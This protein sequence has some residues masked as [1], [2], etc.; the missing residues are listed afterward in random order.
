[1]IL[2]LDY[3]LE[4]GHAA[5]G[6][7][8]NVPLAALNQLHPDPF[9]WLVPGMLKEKIVALIK[10]LPKHL[11]V[12]FVP[13]PQTADTVLDRLLPRRGNLLDLLA[14]EL[15]NLAGIPV[16]R[17]DFDL[18]SIDPY[19]LMNFRILDDR[20][21]KVLGMGR[22]LGDLQTRLG[23]EAAG[24]FGSVNESQFTRN[25]ITVWDFGDL[26]EQVSVRR[27]GVT[28]LGYPA[29]A[30]RGHH[31]ALR[32]H[33]S[34]G[35][36]ASL[37]RGGLRRL[38]ALQLTTDLKQLGHNIAG[39]PQLTVKFAPLG[40]AG[41]LRKQLLDLAVERVYLADNAAVRTHMEF[42][43][44]LRERYHKLPDAIRQGCT[45]VGQILD[46]YHAVALQLADKHPASWTPA[47]KDIRE[48]LAILLAPGFIANTP[49]QWLQQFPRYLRAIQLRLQKLTNAGLTRDAKHT[50]DFTPQHTRYLER[51]SHHRARSI[52]D[53]ELVTFRWMLEELRVSYYAQELG[54][55]VPVSVKKMDQQW[56]RVRM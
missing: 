37:M 24:S 43:L 4:P 32:L 56:E 20:G 22:D 54:T 51:L 28:M 14:S 19:L 12:V 25:N 42:E 46:A 31:V 18:N 2:P 30:D 26:P 40:S 23:A 7:T 6:V 47:I 16:R 34:P 52:E 11:R 13:A 1:M 9:D 44:R 39:F 45:T 27:A 49:W 48:Q 3:R 15:G 41:E 5:D 55:A 35:T 10:A 53:P 17:S 8:L 36:A 50:A 29:L 21:N 33:D 38:F